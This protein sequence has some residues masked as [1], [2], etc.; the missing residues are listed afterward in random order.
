M[1]EGSGYSETASDRSRQNSQRSKA[2]CSIVPAAMSHSAPSLCYLRPAVP[3]YS[4]PVPASPRPT[5]LP[6]HPSCRCSSNG[7][8][9]IICPISITVPLHL[10]TYLPHSASWP[11]YN[12]LPRLQ[13][14]MEPQLVKEAT[15]LP[16]RSRQLQPRKLSPRTLVRATPEQVM[17]LITTASDSW[18]ILS[19]FASHPLSQATPRYELPCFS[20]RPMKSA[21]SSL[22]VAMETAGVALKQSFDS[23]ALELCDQNW[24]PPTLS[25][26][27][28]HFCVQC[29]KMWIFSPHK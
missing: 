28:A 12:W 29:N 16:C 4:V 8:S 20:N 5:L 11:L 2:F 27:T 24:A 26:W 25:S 14:D 3:G 13:W 23:C 21:A 18:C 17:V 1:Q 10:G 7:T 9:S 19:A 15:H 22:G 6:L